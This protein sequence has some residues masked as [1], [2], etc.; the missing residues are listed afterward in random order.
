MPRPFPVKLLIVFLVEIVLTEL[1][2]TALLGELEACI[3]M[4]TR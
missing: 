4:V 3:G 1:E 2:V